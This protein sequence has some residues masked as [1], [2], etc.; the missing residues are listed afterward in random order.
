MGKASH[1]WKG[2]R[3]T[4][5][6]GYIY[7]YQ[8]EHPFNIKKY[9]LE[10][11]LVMEKHLGRYLKKGETVHHKNGIR[12]DNRIENLELWVT[13]QPYGQRVEDLV[14]FVADCYSENVQQKINSKISVSDLEYN[15]PPTSVE[16]NNLIPIIK[17]E[18]WIYPS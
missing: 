5:R 3:Y 8:P 18:D 15:V 16:A 2:G 6:E 17:E 9:V 12:D 14:Q 10:H 11:R 13:W 4:K 7:V 1:L